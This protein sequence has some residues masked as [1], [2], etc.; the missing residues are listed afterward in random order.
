M[1]KPAPVIYGGSVDAKNARGIMSVKNV[2]GVM[3]GRASL[4]P[5]DFLPIIESGK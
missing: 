4:T 2:D 3:V 5:A 1:G